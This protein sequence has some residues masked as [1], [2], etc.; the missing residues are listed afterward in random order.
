[1][2]WGEAGCKALPCLAGFLARDDLRRTQGIRK[3]RRCHG[4]NGRVGIHRSPAST[5]L[6]SQA[7]RKSAKNQRKQVQERTEQGAKQI[8]TDMGKRK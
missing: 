1:M 6:V 4:K 7:A 2:R 5:A 3:P 8:A